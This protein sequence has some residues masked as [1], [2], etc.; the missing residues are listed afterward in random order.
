MTWLL[1]WLALSL[2]VGIAVGFWLRALSPPD[3]DVVEDPAD[4]NAR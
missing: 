3:E 1:A 4:W 2:P